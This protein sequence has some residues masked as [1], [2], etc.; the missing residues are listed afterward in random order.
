MDKGELVPDEV[1]IG[2]IE[3]RLAGADC[4]KG[5][6]LD[7]FPRTVKQAD[8]LEITL[9]GLGQSIEHVIEVEVDSDELI[10]RL[11]GRRTCRNCGEGYHVE[12]NRPEKDGLCDKCGGELYQRD[13]DSEATITERLRVYGEQT[14]P[15][16]EYYSK[17]DLLTSV[18]GLGK[19]E[20]IFDRIN[21]VIAAV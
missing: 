7:G 3:E 16:T 12:F 13:D 18:N 9:E 20:E 17:K 11:S 21:S 19:E 8:A 1:V 10:K 5:F 4:S 2:I 6:I 14:S 15:L